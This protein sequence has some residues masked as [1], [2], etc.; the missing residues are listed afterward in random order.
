MIGTTHSQQ[1]LPTVSRYLNELERHPLLKDGE[2]DRFIARARAGD[3]TAFNRIVQG[4]LR[5]VVRVASEHTHMG[6]PLDD[7]IAEGN[8]GL[9]RAVEKFD[10]SLGYQF[11]TYAVWWIRNAIQR[12][13]RNHRH[14]VRLPSNRFED[15]DKLRKSAE[16][17]SQDRG[18][19]VSSQE[20]G[21]TLQMTSR[22]TQAAVNLMDRPVSLDAPAQETNARE[23]HEYIPDRAILPDEFT[24]KK[25]DVQ[26]VRTALQTLNAR[27]AEILSLTFGLDHDEPLNLAQVG[28]RFGISK[29]RVRQLRNRAM[30]QLRTMLA[31]EGGTKN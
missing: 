31:G 12:A 7:L 28:A 18:R 6:L 16:R 11:T 29:E 8:L 13:I 5:F 15:L 2:F 30:D 27:D 17:L 20:A 4:N 14:P 19:Y 23:L 24:S 9:I 25:Q 1:A 3:R 26:R 10:P 21:R 22:R